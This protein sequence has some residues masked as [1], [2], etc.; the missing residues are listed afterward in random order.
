QAELHHGRHIEGGHEAFKSYFEFLGGVTTEFDAA[1]KIARRLL[2]GVVLLL[3]LGGGR[4][5]RHIGF[6][7]GLD[8]GGRGFG[9]CALFLRGR[10]RNWRRGGKRGGCGLLRFFFVGS[11]AKLSICGEQPPVSHFQL[12]VFFSVLSHIVFLFS[13]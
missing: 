8:A 1:V 5:F 11:G 7:S 12:A 6:G 2:V 9:H 4:R 13:G 3:L 10:G